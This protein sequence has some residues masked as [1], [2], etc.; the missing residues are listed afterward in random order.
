MSD[1]EF[2]RRELLN[3]DVRAEVLKHLEAL[4]LEDKLHPNENPRERSQ[5]LMREAVPAV[6]RMLVDLALRAQDPKIREAALD[7]LLWVAK[8]RTE[9]E[10]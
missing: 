9:Q 10:K 7:V 1:E 4:R 6:H 5:R 8:Q 3:F 2:I